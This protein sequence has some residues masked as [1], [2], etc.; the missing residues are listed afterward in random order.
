MYT[1][2][3]TMPE[4]LAWDRLGARI[5]LDVAL[6]EVPLCHPCNADLQR[7]TA[8]WAPPVTACKLAGTVRHCLA[9]VVVALAVVHDMVQLSA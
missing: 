7:W 9:H 5:A 6:G 8:D 4:V 1:V 2:L 3:K